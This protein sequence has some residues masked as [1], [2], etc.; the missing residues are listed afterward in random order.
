MKRYIRMIICSLIIMSML[1]SNVYAIPYDPNDYTSVN[2]FSELLPK[3]A[4]QD[5]VSEYAR[6]KG[7]F[8]MRA[9][10]AISNEGEGDIGAVA[11]AYMAVPADEVYITLYLDRWDE[12]SERWRQVTFYDAEFYAKDYPDGLNSPSLNLTFKKQKK[13]YYY[14]LRGVFSA[15]CNGSYEGFSPVTDGVLIQ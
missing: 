3:S 9:D 10:L 14:R 5:R 13:G 15:L 7:D 2:E 8:F 12:D 1:T 4:R 6:A 11:I